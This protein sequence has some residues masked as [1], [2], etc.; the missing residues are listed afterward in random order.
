MVDMDESEHGSCVESPLSTRNSEDSSQWGHFIDVIPTTPEEEG[1]DYSDLWRSPNATLLSSSPYSYQP[2]FK[3][4]R[5]ALRKN[6]SNT[7][8]PGFFLI[9]PAEASTEDHVMG[10]L[11]RMHV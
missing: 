5:M 8:L 10:A 2:Y 3:P 1:E 4:K 9:T 7:F 6:T 11:K